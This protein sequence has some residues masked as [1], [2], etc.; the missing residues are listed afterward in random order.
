MILDT[1]KRVQKLLNI[2]LVK[3]CIWLR[4]VQ[5]QKVKEIGDLTIEKST[6][7]V[8]VNGGRN[9]NGPKVVKFFVR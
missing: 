2:R 3:L 5:Y 4:F 1:G 8:P 7:E 9:Y 6:T